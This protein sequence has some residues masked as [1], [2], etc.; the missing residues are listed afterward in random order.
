MN[1]IKGESKAEIRSAST[2]Q[3]Q[4]RTNPSLLR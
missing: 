2:R 4:L 1:V 3:H